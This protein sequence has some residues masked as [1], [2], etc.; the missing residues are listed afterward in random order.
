M[1][2]LNSWFLID[3]C[4]VIESC[5]ESCSLDWAL[6]A[7]SVVLTLNSSLL[8]SFLKSVADLLVQVS[9]FSFPSSSA[10]SRRLF[11]TTDDSAEVKTVLRR[12]AVFCV[13]ELQTGLTFHIKS[14][15]H[16]LM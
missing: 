5:D 2:G 9:G 3:P 14:H 1:L 8:I 12:T 16:L 10:S 13:F 11:H 6:L 4:T 15:L 7:G